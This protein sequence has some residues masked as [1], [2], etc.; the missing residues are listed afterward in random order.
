M[1]YNLPELLADYQLIFTADITARIYLDN[2][3]QW[4]D[5]AIKAVNPDMAIILDTITIPMRV[6]F[7]LFS[8]IDSICVDDVGCMA[9]ICFS[10]Y[11]YVHHSNGENDSLWHHKIDYCAFIFVFSVIVLTR[12]LFV[13]TYRFIG[14]SLILPHL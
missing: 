12:Y 8:H 1:T 7:S 3:T 6:L 11:Q 5:P 14:Q 13:D 9:F 2:I 4:N 10:N